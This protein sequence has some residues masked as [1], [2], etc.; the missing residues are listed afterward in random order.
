L[1]ASAKSLSEAGPS[2]WLEALVFPGT[3]SGEMVAYKA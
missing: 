2:R 1:T 3:D